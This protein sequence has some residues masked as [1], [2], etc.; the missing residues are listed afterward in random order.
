MGKFAALKYFV[1]CVVFVLWGCSSPI[2]GPL[3]E[4]AKGIRGEK[5]PDSSAPGRVEY[6]LGRGDEIEI[7]LL[8]HQEL[9]Q[10]MVIRPDGRISFPLI[11]EIDA[12]GLTPQ[13]KW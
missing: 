7:K 12:I 11:G 2:S 6:R 4:V 10:Q 13:E 1:L 9:N 5:R 3:F 8:Y